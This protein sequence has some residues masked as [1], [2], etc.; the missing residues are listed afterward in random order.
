MQ[1]EGE[2]DEEEL[3]PEYA[4]A[5]E[6]LDELGQE[7]DELVDSQRHKQLGARAEAYD[8]NTGSYEVTLVSDQLAS[9]QMFG[10]DCMLWCWKPHVSVT[11]HG[12][13]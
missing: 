11:G 3:E 2:E 10:L 5:D 4:S 6:G 8:E 7:A 9:K 12:P 1:Y 13:T